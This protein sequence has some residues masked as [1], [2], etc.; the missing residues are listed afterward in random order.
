M[1]AGDEIRSPCVNVCALD[2][3]RYCTGCWRHIDEIVAWRQLGEIERCEVVAR[4]RQRRQRLETSD[5]AGV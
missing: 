1:T 4:A 5:Q 3:D 2:R